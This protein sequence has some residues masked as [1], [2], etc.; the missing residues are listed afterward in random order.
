MRSPLWSIFPE[1]YNRSIIK[2]VANNQQQCRR[3]FCVLAFLAR[4]R[5]FGHIFGHKFRTMRPATASDNNTQHRDHEQN[6]VQQTARLCH[7][8]SSRDCSIAKYLLL[9]CCSVCFYS[10]VI[11]CSKQLHTAAQKKDINF[12]HKVIRIIQR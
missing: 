11:F 9:Y 2:V 12:H 7:N 1:Q 8:H 3:G 6:E 10:S 4:S 5:N